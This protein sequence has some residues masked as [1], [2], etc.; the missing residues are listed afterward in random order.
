MAALDGGYTQLAISGTEWSMEQYWEL[1]G[2]Y[3]NHWD[4]GKSPLKI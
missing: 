1:F 3:R 4:I 2:S